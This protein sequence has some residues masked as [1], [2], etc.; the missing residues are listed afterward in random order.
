MQMTRVD[1]IKKKMNRIVFFLSVIEQQQP[2][3]QKNQNQYKQS[4]ISMAKNDND[5]LS[6]HGNTQQTGKPVTSV[7]SPFSQDTASVRR[8]PE[9]M[10]SKMLCSEN[11][12]D[13]NLIFI[14]NELFILS[15]VVCV[16]VCMFV[17]SALD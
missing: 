16:F 14:K 1:Q 13:C 10:N 9:I 6:L 2:S 8:E 7:K 3:N 12:S 5:D 17:S 4:N 11:I 15:S